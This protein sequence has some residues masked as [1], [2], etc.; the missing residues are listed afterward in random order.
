MTSKYSCITLLSLLSVLA[1]Q[2]TLHSVIL[3][4]IL[5]GYVRAASVVNQNLAVSEYCLEGKLPA[6]LGLNMVAK[7]LV[8]L[9]VGQFFGAYE[10]SGVS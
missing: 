5:C 2:N 7:G 9:S 3:G 10:C 8:V 6:A 4:S 1:E